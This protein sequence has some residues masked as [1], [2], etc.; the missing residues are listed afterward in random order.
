M[1][2]EGPSESHQ[3][4]LPSVTSHL[5]GAWRVSPVHPHSSEAVEL[6]LEWLP[7]RR[8]WCPWCP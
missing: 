3:S 8:L 7:E 4:P 1:I 6:L 5:M 2:I